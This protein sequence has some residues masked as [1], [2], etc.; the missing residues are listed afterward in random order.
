MTRIRFDDTP[1]PFPIP[2]GGPVGAKSIRFEQAWI[3][4]L[5]RPVRAAR[6]A[7]RPLALGFGFVSGLFLCSTMMAP[8]AWLSA[9]YRQAELEM[10]H[11]VRDEVAGA[12]LSYQ[13]LAP[14]V[15]AA[16]E[17]ALDHVDVASDLVVQAVKDAIAE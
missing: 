1:L 10:R 13:I 14:A 8:P 2:F 9:A 16:A 11:V 4:A 7:K 3:M 17:A 12:A 6:A 5:E 15:G